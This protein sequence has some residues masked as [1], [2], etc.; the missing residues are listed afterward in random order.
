MPEGNQD[1]TLA[2]NQTLPVPKRDGT[3]PDEK[4][5]SRRFMAQLK[6]L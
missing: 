3:H 5:L 4:D 1:V 2:E 6:Q